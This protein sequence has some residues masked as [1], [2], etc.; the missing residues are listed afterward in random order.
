METGSPSPVPVFPLPGLVLF[1]HVAIPLR[2]FEHRYRTMVRDALA[3]DRSIAMALLKPGW[4]ADYVGSPEFHSLLC[5]ARIEDVEWQP[6]DCYN[7]VVKGV[8]RAQASRVTREFPY[9]AVTFERRPQHPLIEDDPL[10]AIE[11]ENLLAQFRRLARALERDPREADGLGFEA[12]VNMACTLAPIEPAA[13]LELLADDS[14]FDR[15]LKLRE[16]MERQPLRGPGIGEGEA[17]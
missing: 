10:V 3:R 1:P 9:R 15:A 2:V 4:E 16:W 12:L 17:N 5:L 7:L 14:V 8:A 13:K 11:R 6:D